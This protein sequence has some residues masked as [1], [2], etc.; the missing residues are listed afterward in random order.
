MTR[1]EAREQA[2]LLLFEWSFRED[3]E[4]EEI[5]EL[6]EHCREAPVDDF[7]VKLFA[8]AVTYR[9]QIDREIE[10]HSDKWKL[11]RLS[12]VTL[13]VLRMGVCELYHMEE[14]PPGATINEAVE[15]M[16]KYATEDEASY[17]NGVL[18]ACNRA[19][20]S[21]EDKEKGERADG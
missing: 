21:A 1:R 20:E 10:A 14:I 19:R 8:K 5:V 7:A 4:A 18:G 13:S 15:L 3:E 16:K 11:N 9:L 2:F 17:V 6:A 12:R